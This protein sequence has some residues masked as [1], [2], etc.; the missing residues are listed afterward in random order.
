[1]GCSIN[2]AS[3]GSCVGDVAGAA[4]GDAFHQIAQDFGHTAE[5]VTGWLWGQI[6]SATAVQIGGPAWST[7]WEITGAIAGIVGLGLLVIQVAGSALRQDFGGIGR[8]LRGVIVAFV[9]SAFALAVLES[10]LVATDQLSAGV[11]QLGLGTTNWQQAGAMLLGASVVSALSDAAL[12]IVAFGMIGATIIVWLAL[13]VRKLLLIITAVFA[14]VAF[15]GSL[16]DI[17]RGWVRKWIEM[18]VALVVSKLLLVII[19]V[20]GLEVMDNG[21]GQAGS[22]T[23]QTVTQVAT[24]LLILCVAGFAPWLALKL[25]HFAGDAF[26]Q[27]HAHGQAA[28]AG[29]Q[30]AVAA[31]K[32]IQSGGA[33][34]TRRFASRQDGGGRQGTQ[35][36][37]GH[38]ATGKTP[39]SG[40]PGAEAAAD[41]AV[42]GA[43]ATAAAAAK[44]AKAAKDKVAEDTKQAAGNGQQAAEPTDG[45]R[46]AT[47]PH[48]PRR[49]PADEPPSA[50]VGAQ[51]PQSP[52]PRSDGNGQAAPPPAEGPSQ[53]AASTPRPPT[54]KGASN[55]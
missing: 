21:L 32:K 35:T 15:A 51:R 6:D 30:T 19:F 8:G 40:S 48:P 54:P 27:V 11:M 13:M 36:S 1:M 39:G 20:V 46:P 55:V 29:A 24:G 28:V 31:P 16:A 17:T 4:A 38:P 18:T 44:A 34:I 49:G 37:G 45:Q 53:P 10:L 5:H 25:V 14:P 12:L 52:T 2:P 33:N 41:G 22:G 42:A 3:W 47:P 50:G 23:V 43:A 9:G 7:S 26:H